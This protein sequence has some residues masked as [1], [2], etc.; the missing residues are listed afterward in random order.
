L[1]RERLKQPTATRTG[2]CRAITTTETETKTIAKRILDKIYFK[3]VLRSNS[4]SAG[5]E[6]AY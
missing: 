6:A 3:D 2:Y 4:G 5:D 1:S